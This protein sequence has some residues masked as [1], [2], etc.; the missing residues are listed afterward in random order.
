METKIA[1]PGAAT[2]HHAVR[3]KVRALTSIAPHSGMGGWAPSPRKDS[4]AADNTASG[5]A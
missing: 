2:V 4:A 1:K 3:M 5:V